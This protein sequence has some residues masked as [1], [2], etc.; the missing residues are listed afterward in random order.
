[1]RMMGERHGTFQ[2][3]GLKLIGLGR[4]KVSCSK[5]F[6][7]HVFAQGDGKPA[8]SAPSLSHARPLRGS[9]DFF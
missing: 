5:F 4:N 6:L 7:Q 1:M 2:P 3:V 9:A 8:P